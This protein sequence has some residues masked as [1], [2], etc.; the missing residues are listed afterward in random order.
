MGLAKISEI[1]WLSE[2]MFGKNLPEDIAFI[3]S[4]LRT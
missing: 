3:A 2:K 1:L 4:P